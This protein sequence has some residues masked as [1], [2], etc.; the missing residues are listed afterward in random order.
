MI[1]AIAF[2]AVSGVLVGIN[3]QVNGRLGLSTSPLSASL[4][5]HLVGFV[6]LTLLATAIGGVVSEEAAQSPWYA[7]LGGPL[8][9]IFVA[10]SSWL[11]PR[12]GAVHTTLLLI[13]G[14][15]V[16]GVLMD[17][18]RGTP[19]LLWARILGIAMILFGM[20]LT[21]RKGSTNSASGQR[22]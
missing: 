1:A 17:V 5:N 22:L 10:T 6:L 8:G 15:M 20:L 18:I 16:S 14:Q 11:I 2:A 21:Q 12:I 19:G 4:V 3:R 7:Y 9:V 13:S